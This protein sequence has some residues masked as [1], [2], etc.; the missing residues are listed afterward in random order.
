MQT[1]GRPLK[2]AYTCGAP[3]EYTKTL[4]L[5]LAY[6]LV[7][8]RPVAVIVGRAGRVF[9]FLDDYEIGTDVIE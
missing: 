4:V 7:R 2:W 1:F 8:T 3:R 5:I 6:P 9:A